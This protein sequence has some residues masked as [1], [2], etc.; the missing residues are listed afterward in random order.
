MMKIQKPTETDIRE[1]DE[2]A[3]RCLVALIQSDRGYTD[4]D[5]HADM[6]YRYAAAVMNKRLE[7]RAKAGDFAKEVTGAGGATLDGGKF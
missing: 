1:L 5:A 3:M 2:I 6:A 4:P 7:L